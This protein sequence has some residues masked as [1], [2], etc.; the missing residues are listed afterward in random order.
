[1]AHSVKLITCEDDI[2]DVNVAALEAYRA[3]L[4]TIKTVDSESTP[5]NKTFGVLERHLLKR[6]F[7]ATSL[8]TTK[9]WN[10]ARK[11][12]ESE[13]KNGAEVEA[14]QNQTLILN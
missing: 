8:D 3:R 5:M 12:S 6:R 10:A 14:K 2:T 1:M 9:P 13:K 11:Q 7:G 4:A